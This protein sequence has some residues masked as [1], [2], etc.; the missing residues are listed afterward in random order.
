MTAAVIRNMKI[1]LTRPG[2]ND[3]LLNQRVSVRLAGNINGYIDDG[4]SS[5]SL[6]A[7]KFE[8]RHFWSDPASGLLTMPLEANVYI[9]PA[10]TVWSLKILDRKSPPI[11]FEAPDGTTG[12]DAWVGDN[13]VPNP[14]NP[15]PANGVT[16]A[17]LSAFEAEVATEFAALPGTYALLDFLAQDT[18]NVYFPAAKAGMTTDLDGTFYWDPGYAAVAK[19][20]LDTD[21]VAYPVAIGA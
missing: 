16:Q 18:D 5:P 14:T 19:L 6:T 20:V 11:T 1:Y 8:D 3:P 4:Q 10:G 7:G 9:T 15:F 12:T 2:S 17:E 21:N 13:L